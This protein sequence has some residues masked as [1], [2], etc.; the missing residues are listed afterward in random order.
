VPTLITTQQRKKMSN[1][2]EQLFAR[3]SSARAAGS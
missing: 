1:A 2:K 3:K